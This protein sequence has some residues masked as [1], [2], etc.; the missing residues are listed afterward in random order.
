MQLEILRL[1]AM[2]L[3]EEEATAEEKKQIAAAKAEIVNGSKVK[4]DELAEAIG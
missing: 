4:P 2:L 1:R 3:S